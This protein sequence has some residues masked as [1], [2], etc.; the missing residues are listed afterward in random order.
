MA[1]KSKKNKKKL[2]RPKKRGRKKNYYK[3]K[4]KS[5]TKSSSK[6]TTYSRVRHILWL[7]HK[8]DFLDYRSFISSK[9]DENGNKIKGTSIVSLVFN[10]CKSIECNDEDILAIYKQLKIDKKD[11]EDIPIIPDIFYDPESYWKLLTEDYWDGLDERIWVVSP[12]LLYNP[13]YFLGILGSDRCVDKDNNLKD[14]GKCDE[15]LGDRI[16]EGKRILFKPFVN[17]CNNLQSQKI[18]VGTDEQPHFRFAGET[19]DDR[20]VYWSEENKRWEVRII[21]CN[22]FG[23]VEDYDFV[24]SDSEH[25]ID[26]ES[27]ELIKLKP[28]VEK[29][30]DEISSSIENELE[31]KKTQL[32]LEKEIT[33]QKEAEV[34]LKK[35]EVEIEKEITSRKKVENQMKIIDLFSDGKIS[36]EQME[37]LLN[38]L[39]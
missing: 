16:V 24:P 34:E 9:V 13:D 25:L 2:G 23:D 32:E 3:S 28:K 8:N 21:I 38:K 1:E 12:M 37:S 14:S 39:K 33:K 35:A 36:V 10:E 20:S 18:L 15:K 17:Y 19:D 29:K 6:R 7:N 26:V 11:D 22:V 30:E 31:L 4:K 27:I 5:I